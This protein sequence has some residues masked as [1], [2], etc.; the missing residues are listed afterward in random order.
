MD[1][2][3][4]MDYE[5][6]VVGAGHAG[7]EAAWVASRMGR[8][9]LLLTLNL[10][11][12]A[13]M[14]CNPAIGGIAKGQIVRELDAMGGLMGRAIDRTGIQ[15]RTLNRSKGPAVRSLRAQADK[16]AYQV[17]VRRMLVAEPNLSIRQ[18][19]VVDLIVEDGTARGIRLETGAEIRA[20]ALVLNPG[21][22]LRGQ[23]HVGPASYEGGR[24]G[25]VSAPHLSSVLGGYGIRMGRMKT[26]TPPRVARRSVDFSRLE[27]QPGEEPPPP[28]SHFTRK[29][30]VE[31][32]S[33]YLTG[34]N[35]G[36]HAIIRGNLGASPLYSGRI[37]GIGPRYCP[38]IEDKVVK[39]PERDAHRI[40]LEPE[41]RTT[42]EIY[43]NGV[44]TSLPEDV[45]L[46][47]LRTIPGLERAEILRPGYAVEYDFADPTQLHPT[48]E[49]RILGRVF[50]AGQING[51]TGYEEAA[52]QGLMAGI[53]AALV[54]R[55]SEPIVL[56]R[57]EAYIGVLVDDL[58]TKGTDEPY[59]MFT[60][61]AEHRLILR[62]DNADERLM[63]RGRELGLVSEEEHGEW[64]GI[65]AEV[66]EELGRLRR[67]LVPAE[68][69]RGSFPGLE[70]DSRPQ[71][72]L[73]DVLRRPGLSYGEVVGLGDSKASPRRE[74]SPIVPEL[75]ETEIK[76]EGYVERERKRVARLDELESRR[77]PPEIF[78]LP[79]TGISFEALSKLRAVRPDS[80]GR[81]SRISGVS[82]ADVSV[83]TVYLERHLRGTRALATEV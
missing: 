70:F 2:S 32:I 69:L 41:G 12:I 29:L 78:D 26:G 60:S 66:R 30:E 10:D 28:F 81:A 20:G 13:Q 68:T 5:V 17:E 15:F 16:K 1:G 63:R 79:L 75:V 55:G 36:T 80:V 52:A 25:E 53:N 67:T 46:E 6:V 39:F 18:G 31:Q 57:W 49:S 50:L 24:S 73:A 65:R 27:E 56:R 51:T 44:S 35:P 77:I 23:I 37:R 82:P 47:F 33:C 48:L 21:T 42:E 38:S 8:K 61:M 14:S 45:Q 83:L 40:Y 22:F 72:S 3:G 59:R 58:V 54:V 76:Y 7:C 62:N 11:N 71:H 64:L 43:V 19:R 4:N 74:T 34:T 9:T